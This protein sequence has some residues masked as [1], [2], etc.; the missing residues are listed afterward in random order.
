MRFDRD[1]PVP[2]TAAGTT[3]QAGEAEYFVPAPL[4]DSVV[5]EFDGDEPLIDGVVGVE[6][7]PS[8]V[9]PAD[10]LGLLK[11]TANAFLGKGAS[12]LEQRVLRGQRHYWRAVRAKSNLFDYDDMVQ[13]GY[14][15]LDR[16]ARKFDPNRG[17]RFSSYAI[18]DIGGA[19]ARRAIQSYLP[20]RVPDGVF[21]EVIRHERDL[22]ALEYLQS[23]PDRYYDKTPEGADMDGLVIYSL[24]A[25]Q[26]PATP[27][28]DVADPTTEDRFYQIEDRR[29]IAGIFNSSATLTDR[30]KEIL[31]RRHGFLTEGKPE[32]L[33][34]IGQRFGLTKQR[35]YQIEQ[36]ALEKLRAEL[37]VEMENRTGK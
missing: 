17:V 13:D 5:P 8:G 15:G 32:E 19:I 24:S 3:E 20:W 35:V 29:I 36:R 2:A 28:Q 30:E 14:F 23:E 10:H 34:H 7:V 26:E 6:P 21:E 12:P 4:L 18:Y 27:V 25:D 22:P 33:G 16:A 1:L 31:L 11:S 9:D 37:G